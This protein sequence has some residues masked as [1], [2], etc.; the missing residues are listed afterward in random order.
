MDE[1]ELWAKQEQ[2]QE[3]EVVITHYV[4][5]ELFAF[6]T[7]QQLKACGPLVNRMEA[8]LAP[9]CQP[10]QQL[11]HYA[12]EQYVIVRFLP[13]ARDKFL[14]GLVKLYQQGE[15]LV[16]AIDYGFTIN[17]RARDMWRMPANLCAKC[18]QIN[19]GGVAGVAPTSGRTW[20]KLAVA[21]LNKRLDEAKLHYR[22]SKRT[23]EHSFGELAIESLRQEEPVLDAANYLLD[24]HCAIR[25]ER[26]ELGCNLSLAYDMELAELNDADITPSKRAIN[27]LEQMWKHRQ[28]MP[29]NPYQ[30][31]SAKMAGLTNPAMQSGRLDTLLQ[32]RKMPRAPESA[33]RLSVVRSRN[34]ASVETALFN[35]CSTSS[36]DHYSNCSSDSIDSAKSQAES[37]PRISRNILDFYRHP[38]IPPRIN[39]KIVKTTDDDSRLAEKENEKLSKLLREDYPAKAKDKP[40]RKQD[41]SAL[42]ESRSKEQSEL[43]QEAR[44]AGKKT[45]TKPLDKPML[46]QDKQRSQ[47]CPA[48]SMSEEV[49]KFLREASRNEKLLPMK[50]PNKHR[51]D[52]DQPDLAKFNL[53]PVS[54]CVQNAKESLNKPQNQLNLK[55]Q[56]FQP[57]RANAKIARKSKTQ[58]VLAHSAEQVQPIAHVSESMLCHDVQ[59][60]M[61]EMD[62]QLP[63]PTQRYAWP[64]LMMGNSCV[65]VDNAVRGRSWCYLPALCSLVIGS[66][67]AAA[68]GLG[69]LALLVADSAEQAVILSKHCKTLMKFYETQFAKV[70][71]TH[72]NSQVD[73]QLMLLNS[74]GILVTTP[75]HLKQLLLPGGLE[76]ISPRR[77]KYFVLDDYDRMRSE[78]TDVLPLISA[79]NLNRLQ[80]MLVA[81]QW[82]ARVFLDLINRL[83][84]NPLL[85]FGDFL[86]A[87]IYGNLKLDIALLRSDTKIGQLIRYLDAQRSSRRHIAV[88]CKHEAE[89]RVLKDA[90]TEAGHECIG[91]SDAVKQVG[92]DHLIKW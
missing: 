54:K 81:Q 86:K 80:L 83:A 30:Q 56:P 69:P 39:E 75:L 67:R 20:S 59:K 61:I 24:K 23:A 52:Q 64:H 28:Q 82:H 88:Y 46:N 4:N 38:M 68:V 74:C 7:M 15:Y 87:A 57:V 47:P 26:T 5:P 73:V 78:L 11:E 43:F 8:Q 25:Q 72:E 17:C 36:S 63:M 58:Q 18:L 60:A 40:K 48:K 29:L 2:E 85:L 79:L 9:H 77:L 66:M 27:I 1:Q 14:R 50:P 45:N 13:W 21:V 22:I 76:L 35:G 41:Q 62:L 42:A 91:A 3:E 53:E 51:L 19:W 90:L 84:I 44:L 49:S 33:M 89:L 6:I 32:A 10:N 12:P 34:E 92:A 55:Q 37:L 71:N 70:V 65:L 31:L 16:W